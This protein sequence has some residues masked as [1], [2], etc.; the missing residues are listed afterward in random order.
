MHAAA[1]TVQP[2][3]RVLYDQASLSE[4]SPSEDVPTRAEQIVSLGELSMRFGARRGHAHDRLRGEMD[5]ANAADVE[6]E[7][8]RVE[9]TDATTIVLDLAELS[10]IDSTGIRLLLMADGRSRAERGAP[11]A[12]PPARGRAARPAPRGRR[13]SPALHRRRLRRARK[14]AAR[15]QNTGLPV[16]ILEQLGQPSISASSAASAA[17]T[18][19]S[20]PRRSCRRARPAARRRRRESGCRGAT[21]GSRGVGMTRSSGGS[22]RA[23][24]S[25]AAVLRSSSSGS[26]SSIG[27]MNSSIGGRIGSPGSG[28]I[29]GVSTSITCVDEREAGDLAGIAP[30]AKGAPAIGL[31]AGGSRRRVAAVRD[32]AVGQDL[33]DRLHVHARAPDHDVIARQHAACVEAAAPAAVAARA[34][35][36]LG[37][38]R[39]DARHPPRVDVRDARDVQRTH[40]TTFRARR[41]PRAP[42]R[43]PRTR[44]AP[45]GSRRRVSSLRLEPAGCSVMPSRS[46]SHSRARLR[47]LPDAV[48]SGA[49]RARVMG[50]LPRLVG[51]AVSGRD[52]QGVIAGTAVAR[53]SSRSP[54]R[55]RRAAFVASRAS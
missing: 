22:S 8:L 38:D 13:G 10:F 48:G 21:P 39:L 18:A 31:R 51:H 7:L 53:R 37:L 11:R 17:A 27:M 49:A 52:H 47:E 6:K 46:A 4:S 44:S 5:I 9:A 41:G 55:G 32:D 20:S 3:R 26:S 36:R 23:A 28:S 45:C 1:R 30:A 33:A 24:S 19:S 50:R 16:R 25:R 54:R 42:S 40:S 14:A 2:A 43:R 35:A 34:R 29:A 12:A 15:L